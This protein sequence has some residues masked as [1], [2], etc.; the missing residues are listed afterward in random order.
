[1]HSLLAKF[2]GRILSFLPILRRRKP[3]IVRPLNMVWRLFG[4]WS[5]TIRPGITPSE[6]VTAQALAY[7]RKFKQNQEPLLFFF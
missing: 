5:W 2:H 3:C 1:M 7:E 4:L 6:F